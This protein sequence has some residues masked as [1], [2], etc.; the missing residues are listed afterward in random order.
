MVPYFF[1]ED[2]ALEWYL[3]QI[4]I[5]APLALAGGVFGGI[6]SFCTS[7]IMSYW[8]LRNVRKRMQKRAA[9]YTSKHG[10]LEV[11]LVISVLSDA[12]EA[13]LDYM[14]KQ[15]KRDV[16]LFQTHRK[17]GFGEAETDWEGF[18]ERV[19]KEVLKIREMGAQ[20][21]F[22]FTKVPVPIAIMIGGILANGPEVVLHHFESGVYRPSGRLSI[23]TTRL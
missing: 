1:L 7:Q 9:A 11:A 2:F 4:S 10:A 5:N 18:L 14:A 13:A 19:K 6:A 15:G 8:F 3:T 12:K 21:I 17:E 20:R 23:E 22:L 16:L